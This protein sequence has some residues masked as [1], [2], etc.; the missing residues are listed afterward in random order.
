M[1]TKYTKWL[2]NTSYGYKIHQMATKY[3]KWLQNT[4]NGHNIYQNLPLKYPPKFTQIG[5][6]V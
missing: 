1:A 6:W 5:I 4:P 2:Q 3:T